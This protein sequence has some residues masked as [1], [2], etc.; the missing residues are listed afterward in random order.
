MPDIQSGHLSNLLEF[1]Y[2]GKCQ[3][4]QADF[5]E[6]MSCGRTLGVKNLNGTLKSIDT[7]SKP[8]IHPYT[9]ENLYIEFR[10]RGKGVLSRQ[11][12]LIHFN[13]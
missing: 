12:Q 6:S 11:N 10:K 8:E 9:S 7:D 1:I 3:V 4:K 5:E 2:Q 13:Q